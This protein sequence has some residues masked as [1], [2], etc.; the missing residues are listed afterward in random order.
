MRMSGGLG[1]G[2]IDEGVGHRGLADTGLSG[3]EH[4][5][6][7]TLRHPPETLPE[8]ENRTITSDQWSLGGTR[9]GRAPRR[10]ALRDRGDEPIASAGQRL[11][12]QGLPRVV[13]EGASDLRD[14]ALQDLRLNVRLGPE[15]LEELIVGDQSTGRRR[16][17]AALQTPWARGE[18]VPGPASPRQRHWSTVS[19]R[20]ARNSLIA[21]P[22]VTLGRLTRGEPSTVALATGIVPHSFGTFRGPGHETSTERLPIDHDSRLAC[23]V[24]CPSRRGANDDAGSR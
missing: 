7:F 12:E 3:D 2:P 22:E 10:R 18:C 11:D 5:L 8:L 24:R 6:P 20:N 4:D 15:R 17:S 19:S 13:P 21:R 9:C 23:T 14:V 1:C 16:G